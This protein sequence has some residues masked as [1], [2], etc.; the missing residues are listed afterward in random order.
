MGHG[1]MEA[2]PVTPEGDNTTEGWHA[3]IAENEGDKITLIVSNE[4]VIRD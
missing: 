3:H 4:T 1:T 2:V